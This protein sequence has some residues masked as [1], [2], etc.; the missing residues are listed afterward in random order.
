MRA[1]HTPSARLYSAARDLL[2]CVSGRPSSW[3]VVLGLVL[4]GTMLNQPA[5]ADRFSYVCE[6]RYEDGKVDQ[7]TV[8][9]DTSIPSIDGKTDGEIEDLGGPCTNRVSVTVSS[10]SWAR[11]CKTVDGATSRSDSFTIDRLTGYYRE[12]NSVGGESHVY[13]ASGTCEKHRT[14]KPPL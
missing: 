10:F 2:V 8:E 9:V 11:E 14:T 6:I 4:L 12:L 7:T 3:V 1:F 13:R 5:H